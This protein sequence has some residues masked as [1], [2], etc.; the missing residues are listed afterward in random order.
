MDH[1][2]IEA[3]CRECA[4]DVTRAK[5]TADELRRRA[6]PALPQLHEWADRLIAHLIH[7]S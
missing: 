1:S 2:G 6:I 7:S 5:Q 3:L 4:G